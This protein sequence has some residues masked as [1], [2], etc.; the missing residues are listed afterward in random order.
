MKISAYLLIIL[1]IASYSV[2]ASENIESDSDQLLLASC[3]ALSMTPEPL[4]ARPCIYFI[5][6]FLAATQAIDTPIINQQTRKE[7]RF[8]ESISRPGPYRELG[9]SARFFP[10]LCA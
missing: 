4:D 10:F 5:Q 6:G 2:F 3:Q 9:P 7:H 1:S 8:Y